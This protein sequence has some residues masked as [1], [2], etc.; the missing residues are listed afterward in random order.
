LAKNPPQAASTH[1]IATSSENSS[2]PR[3]AKNASSRR[4]QPRYQTI[5]EGL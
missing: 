5:V 1:A 2:T 3:N 4:Q